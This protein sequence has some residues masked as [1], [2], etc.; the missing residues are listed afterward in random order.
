MNKK[1]IIIITAVALLLI[2]LLLARCAGGCG[3]HASKPGMTPVRE[4][5][6]VAGAT[7]AAGQANKESARAE[8]KKSAV[9]ALTGYKFKISK[10]ADGNEVLEISKGNNVVYKKEAGKK[11]NI[12]VNSDGSNSKLPVAGQDLLGD[13]RQYVMIQVH[14]SKDSC[15][16]VYVV[17]SVA[18]NFKE[19]A[20][21][22]GLADGVEFKDIDKDGKPE[23]IGRDC[24]FMDW[25]AAFGEAPA[26]K[27]IMRYGDNGFVFAE[28]LMKKDPP[29]TEQMRSY[30]KKNKGGFITWVWKYML[31]LIYSG[32]G[33]KAWK[34]YDMVDWDPD[35]ESQ[36]MQ[37]NTEKEI[38]DKED[39]KQAFKEHLTTSTYWPQLKTFNNWEMLDVEM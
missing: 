19:V 4:T 27:V 12:L 28:D 10:N 15:S 2:I 37:E 23:L 21:I 22:R 16:N 24:T 20:E 5:P 29:S 18:D 36:M 1:I 11:E 13:G 25:W 31:D 8:I 9:P 6:V 32:N 7:P 38:S 35:W 17:L 39:F 33:D 34:F 3:R 14:S 26:P 30:I